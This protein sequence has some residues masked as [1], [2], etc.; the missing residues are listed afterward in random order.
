[1]SGALYLGGV[2]I[3]SRQPSR[4]HLQILE[5]QISDSSEVI[6]ETQVQL[7][8]DEVGG[9]MLIIAMSGIRLLIDQSI[10]LPIKY[11]IHG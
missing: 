1:M 8:S 11:T 3:G 4:E 5:G 7:Y 2:M 9:S 6:S 10:G